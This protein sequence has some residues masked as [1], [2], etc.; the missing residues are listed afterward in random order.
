MKI[1]EMASRPQ[2]AYWDIRGLVEPI[3]LVLRYLEVDFEDIRI[4]FGDIGPKLMDPWFSGQRDS[5]GLDFPNLPY[6]IDEDVKLTQSL[7]IH[8]HIGRK[9][10]L[11]GDTLQEKAT[12]DLVSH[13][14]DGLRWSAWVVYNDPNFHEI[15]Q[16]WKK[17]IPGRL[18]EMSKFLEGKEFVLG[19]K[20]SFV[21]FLLYESVQW[22]RAFAPEVFEESEEIAALNNFQK[23]IEN[24][25]QIKAYMESE[26]FKDWPFFAPIVN[27]GYSKVSYKKNKN[28]TN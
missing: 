4:P 21:D 15:K 23:R 27:F 9:Y 7:A 24:I 14:V 25:P 16:D 12:I 8:Q 10:N 11:Y 6:Y 22:Y 20:I 2:L 28:C 26:D 17:T 3:R 5:L 13:T 19:S 18:S 1:P